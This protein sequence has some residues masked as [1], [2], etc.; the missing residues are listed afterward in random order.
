MCVEPWISA[1]FLTC[2]ALPKNVT[3]V[4]ISDIKSVSY[5]QGSFYK[6]RFWCV[7]GWPSSMNFHIHLYIVCIYLTRNRTL[8]HPFVTSIQTIIYVGLFTIWLYLMLV[9]AG[10]MSWINSGFQ[11]SVNLEES[12]IF[13]KFP[14]S[15]WLLFDVQ[16]FIHYWCTCCDQLCLYGNNLSL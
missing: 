11:F 8:M 10:L 4:K 6:I 15:I 9:T 2:C 12:Y 7:T 5:L 14:T 16:T 3:L 13:C 1:W